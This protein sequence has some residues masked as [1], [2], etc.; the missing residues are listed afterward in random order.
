MKVTSD[1]GVK[2]SV[3]W[4]EDKKK[5]HKTTSEAIYAS[6]QPSPTFVFMHVPSDICL[7]IILL[8]YEMHIWIKG[9]FWKYFYHLLCSILTIIYMK[10][11]CNVWDTW[12]NEYNHRSMFPIEMISIKLFL[13]LCNCPYNYA[14]V[15]NVHFAH[16]G[17]AK[18]PVA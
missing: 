2:C 17:A 6:P 10:D 1:I 9:N 18:V 12:L 15:I 11:V 4:S 16:N 5:Q 3:V 13:A 7:L 8:D 14:L